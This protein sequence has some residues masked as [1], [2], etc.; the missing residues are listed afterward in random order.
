MLSLLVLSL[1]A[2]SLLVLSLLKLDNP[3][4][5]SIKL[6]LLSSGSSLMASDVSGTSS[7]FVC[8]GVAVPKTFDF[9]IPA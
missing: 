1:L 5:S 2:L 6:E 3:D 4:R 9:S 8:V 7:G